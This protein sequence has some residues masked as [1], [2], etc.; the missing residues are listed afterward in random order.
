MKGAV[1]HQ[2]VGAIAL[3][4]P[5]H[6]RRMRDPGS[7]HINRGEVEDVGERVGGARSMAAHVSLPQA[8]S[9][10]A[11]DLIP[12]KGKAIPV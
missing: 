11:G 4:I 6:K 10:W 2:F 8:R 5:Q 9:L 12:E 7:Y 3:E 1:Y